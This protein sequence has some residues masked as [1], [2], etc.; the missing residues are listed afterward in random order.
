ME[1]ESRF[2]M[3]QSVV[4]FGVGDH[5]GGPTREQIL[6]IQSFQQDPIFPH[7]HFIERGRLF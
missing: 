5:G 1:N 2:D 3:P 4:I 7:V 6:R